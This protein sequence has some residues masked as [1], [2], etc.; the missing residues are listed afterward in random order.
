MDGETLLTRQDLIDVLYSVEVDIC[1]DLSYEY[2]SLKVTA[3][4]AQ[5]RL[6]ERIR[7]KLERL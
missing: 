2:D 5:D 4:N 3:L 7:A 6:C 1:R